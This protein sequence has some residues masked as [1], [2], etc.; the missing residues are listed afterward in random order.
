MM[1]DM[2]DTTTSPSTLTATAAAR[3]GTAWIAGGA[4]WLVAGLLHADSGW[5]FDTAALVWLVAD[6][7]IAAGIV[8]LFILRPH[9]HSGIATAALVL[10]LIAR[11]AFT[12]G[13]IASIIEGS[14]EGPLIPLGALLTAVAMTAYGT[15]VLRRHNIEGPGRWSF[16]VMGIYPFVAMVPV[17]A[18]TGEPS[19]VLIAGW[20]FPAMFVGFATLSQRMQTP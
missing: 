14:D 19:Y 7:F 20:G 2:T 1:H 6:L 11:A 3:T 8:G 9:G 5:R 10:A 16:L 15:I 13:E 18:I 4:A 17:L 12:G